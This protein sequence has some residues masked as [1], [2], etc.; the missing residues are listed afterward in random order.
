[1]FGNL[2]KAFVATALTPAAI[3]I[4]VVKLPI[5][6]EDPHRSAFEQTEKMLESVGDNISKALD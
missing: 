3:V 5:T 4:D 6:S 2:L 1:M